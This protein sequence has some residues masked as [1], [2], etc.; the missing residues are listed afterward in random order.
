MNRVLFRETGASLLD[1]AADK[2]KEQG[3]GEGR[4][5]PVVPSGGGRLGEVA[6]EAEGP[7]GDR[8]DCF[9]SATRIAPNHKRMTQGLC[10]LTESPDRGFSV[11]GPSVWDSFSSRSCD[12]EPRVDLGKGSVG[13]FR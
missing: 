2:R 8:A 9:S 7:L 10:N 4:D 1:H 13:G 3:G 12:H 6:E 5:Q 11:C